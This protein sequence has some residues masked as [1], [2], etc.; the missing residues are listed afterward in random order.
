MFLLE[1]DAW[2]I[3][4]SGT[5]GRG[6]FAKKDIAPGVIIGD[7]IG[8]VIPMADESK[9]EG[10]DHFYLMY[11]SDEV[12]ISPNPKT[13]GVHLLNH[14]CTPN[15]W[16]YTYKGHTLYFA[17]RHIFPGEELTISYLLSPQDEECKPCTHL[18]ACN[19]AICHQSMH[20]SEKRYEKWDAFHEKEEQKTTP[21][22]VTPGSML[23][24]LDSYPE[25]IPDNPIYTLF[26]S[27]QKDSLVCEE[28]VMPIVE[29]VRA[30]IRQSGKTLLFPKLHLQVLGVFEDLI[31]T[32]QTAK[33]AV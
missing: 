23:P 21:A 26:G 13:P 29:K 10:D 25:N 18:C 16:M 2:E 4:E 8:E 5:M 1:D 14:S 22:K 19:G 28:N 32:K 20:L 24:L 7:Y 12:T 33:K 3:K 6:V 30:M 11:Y 31:I 9:Y 15:C 17:L 27:N